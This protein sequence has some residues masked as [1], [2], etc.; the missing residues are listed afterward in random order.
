MSDAD[1]LLLTAEGPVDMAAALT[2]VRAHAIDGLHRLEAGTGTLTRR[3]TVAGDSFPITLHFVPDGVALRVETR[4]EGVRS[5]VAARVR[6]WFDLDTP[7]EPIDALLGRDPLFA[8][9]VRA[10]PGV[11]L[12]RFASPFE[13][14]VLI[15][16][17]QQVSLAAGR[18]FAGRLIAAHGIRPKGEETVGDE[19]VGA[20]RDLPA[21]AVLAAVPVDELREQVGLTRGRARTLHEVA[22]LFAEAGI[23]PSTGAEPLPPREAL[24]ALHGVGPW[25]L[26]CLAIRAG[27]DR[28]A[29]P[30]TDAVLRRALAAEPRERSAAPSAE[31]WSPYRSYAT[32]RLWAAAS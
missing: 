2:T 32:A 21:P 6:R 24:H 10:R 20:L 4:D 9:Q 28:D 19:T 30:A 11:R 8:E 18:V 27:E 31:R 23:D 14:A 25:T 17:G 22:A 12:T 26:D 29:F 1:A 5:V 15:V 16:L 7:I 13:A 3:L